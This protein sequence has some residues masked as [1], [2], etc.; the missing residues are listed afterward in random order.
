MKIPPRKKVTVSFGQPVFA[1][2]KDWT[3]GLALLPN[4]TSY[5]IHMPMG[6]GLT[7]QL[8]EGIVDVLVKCPSIHALHCDFNIYSGLLT[9]LTRLHALRSLALGNTTDLMVRRLESLLVELP[10]LTSL[11]LEVPAGMD[12]ELAK[13]F[14]AT[15]ALRS[16]TQLHIGRDHQ[17][18][19]RALLTLLSGTPRLTTLS[20]FYD[21]FIDVEPE[22]EAA[23]PP[24]TYPGL[25]ELRELTVTHQGVARP[26][27]FRV[28]FNWLTTL[29][30][31]AQDLEH[32]SLISDD[33]KIYA[34]QGTAPLGLALRHPK[35]RTFTGPHIVIGLAQLSALVQSSA[36]IERILFAVKKDTVPDFM[37]LTRALPAVVPSLT[38]LDLRVRLED[39]ASLYRGMVARLWHA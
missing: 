24:S 39:S 35:L 8:M 27:Q 15:S 13:E 19:P 28:L 10:S 20:F 5:M 33:G 25:P 14:N 22:L 26:P 6:N 38:T 16:L 23:D 29:T 12:L 18:S 3:G 1:P 7:A 2:A 36:F 37:E 32:M 9:P 34:S 21:N 17:L 30:S 4:A 11:V 31:G